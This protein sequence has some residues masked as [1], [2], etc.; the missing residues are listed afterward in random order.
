MLQLNDESLEGGVFVAS[1]VL[2]EALGG[3]ELLLGVDT[4]EC[5][6]RAAEQNGLV[7][8]RQVV[9]VENAVEVGVVPQ[10]TVGPL[11]QSHG[12]FHL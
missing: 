1:E 2:E 6:L 10:Q 12:T 3:G 7:E 8:G 4:L 5:V 9:F 11:L